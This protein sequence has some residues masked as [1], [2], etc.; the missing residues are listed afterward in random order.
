MSIFWS[1]LKLSFSGLQSF[2]FY[3]ESKKNDIFLLD[4]PK[5]QFKFM[6]A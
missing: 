6:V 5:K 3:P 4:L 2:L 1:F